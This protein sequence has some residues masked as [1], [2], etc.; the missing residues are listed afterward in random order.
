MRHRDTLVEAPRS[1]EE[2]ETLNV[3]DSR[4]FF[5]PLFL[6]LSLS[7]SCVS[8]EIVSRESRLAKG[9]GIDKFYNYREDE[10]TASFTSVIFN[11]VTW[12]LCKN[13][14]VVRRNSE[15]VKR[16]KNN[17]FVKYGDFAE[18]L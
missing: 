9:G 12:A 13:Y 16:Q 4:D 18:K 8:R 7:L 1:A 14:Y 17:I 11:N 3:V 6:S 10:I 2:L 5:S 15:V